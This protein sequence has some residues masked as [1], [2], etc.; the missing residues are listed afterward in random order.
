VANAAARVGV[1]EEWV[2]RKLRTNAVLSMRAGD[3]S[4]AA[5]SLELIGKHLNMFVERK[6]IEISYID[7]ADEYLAKLLELVGQPV[8][9]DKA[10]HALILEHDENDGRKYGSE[11]EPEAEIAYI[12]EE[13]A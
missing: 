11:P 5:R 3:R 4:A 9:E 13:I 7:D 8:L 1:D 2:L 6:S 10:A 12:I